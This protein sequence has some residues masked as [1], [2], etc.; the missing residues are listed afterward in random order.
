MKEIAKEFG[1]SVFYTDTDLFSVICS[2][3]KERFGIDKPQLLPSQAKIEIARE[4][5]FEYNANIKQISRML[6][7]DQ[8]LISNLIS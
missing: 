2:L 8:T 4:M 3:G 6:K 1:E 5:H 7:I